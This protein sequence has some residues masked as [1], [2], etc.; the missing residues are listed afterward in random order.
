MGLLKMMNTPKL[1]TLLLSLSMFF[2][3]IWH[4]G[5]DQCL[6]LLAILALLY[7]PWRQKIFCAK[8]FKSPIT[9]VALLFFAWVIISTLIINTA[10]LP[11]QRAW[12]GVI[13]YDLMLY[14]LVLPCVIKNLK[15]CKWIEQGLILGVLINVIL[16]TFYHFNPDFTLAHLTYHPFNDGGF[17]DAPFRDGVFDN[18]PLPLIFI[19]VLACWILLQRILRK[20]S[21][22]IDIVI[23][24]ALSLYI[25]LINIERSGYLLYIALFLVALYSQ[26]IGRKGFFIGL[27]ALTLMIACLYEGVPTV[28]YR[29]NKGA[30]DIASFWQNSHHFSNIDLT[31]GSFGTRLNFIYIGCD[32]IKSNPL[33]GTGSSGYPLVYSTYAKMKHL[34]LPLQSDNMYMLLA[35]ELGLIGLVLYLFWLGVIWHTIK[36]LSTTQGNALRGLWWMI[37]IMNMTTS[38]FI[39]SPIGGTFIVFLSLYTSKNEV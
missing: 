11:L 3:T 5:A 35:V 7:K 23:F 16:S 36:N 38:A 26:I 33:A 10:H 20:E 32:L 19:V 25:W 22:P 13:M 2:V 28:K 8:N 37:V 17:T 4:W 24:I 39:L 14:L 21:H 18:N 34:S 31:P 12:Y 6:V 29:T 15:H 9:M 1:A 30:E 27:L